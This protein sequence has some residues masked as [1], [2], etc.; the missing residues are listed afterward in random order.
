MSAATQPELLPATAEA[1]LHRTLTA[2]CA[3]LEKNKPLKP[4]APASKPVIRSSS[5]AK[6]ALGDTRLVRHK[7]TCLFLAKQKEVGW[8][9][10]G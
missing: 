1:L 6:E 5:D 10:G 9:R 8:V 4:P 7:Q 3:E 2:S